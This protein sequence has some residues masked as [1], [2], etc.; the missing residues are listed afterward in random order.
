MTK[1]AVHHKGGKHHNMTRQAHNKDT[2]KYEKQAMRTAANKAKHVKKAKEAKDAA[3]KRFIARH[4]TLDFTVQLC[5]ICP[6][7]PSDGGECV[8][9]GR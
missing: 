1:T 5:V 8:S 3:D 6:T 7:K 4:P 2:H 9:P